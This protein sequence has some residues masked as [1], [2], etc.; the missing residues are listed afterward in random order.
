MKLGFLDRSLV[1]TLRS[2]ITLHA[3][4]NLVRARK[5]TLFLQESFFTQCDCASYGSSLKN[6]L[7]CSTQFT[8]LL[9][10]L[11]HNSTR[12][13]TNNPKTL[14][15]NTMNFWKKCFEIKKVKLIL[16]GQKLPFSYPKV[17]NQLAVCN[18]QINLS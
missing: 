17:K 14:E 11:S 12:H 18:R 16:R 1:S 2:E 10:N 7:V 4:R 8:Y 3:A 5:V 6:S 13:L 15:N 9:N